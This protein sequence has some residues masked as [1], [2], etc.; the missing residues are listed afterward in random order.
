M[1][2]VSSEITGTLINFYVTCRREAWLYARKILPNQDDENIEIGR[3]L[4]ELQDEHSDNFEF[5]NLKFDKVAKEQGH[6]VVTEYKKSLKNSDGAFYQLLFYIYLIKTSL[7]LK[8]VTGKVIAKK[9]TILVEDS[10][11]NFVK[12][13][14]LILE[15]EEFIKSPKAP[16]FEKNR[17]CG[18]CGYRDYCI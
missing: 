3:I 12:I 4:A 2:A 11:E 9:S 7:K 15:I 1:I 5:A 10:D 8:K 13:E 16:K 18:G 17:F 6:I 14:N